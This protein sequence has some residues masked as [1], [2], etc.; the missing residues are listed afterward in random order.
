VRL[1]IERRKLALKDLEPFIGNPAQLQ[2]GRPL[3]Q[4]GGM[5]PREVLANWL[6]C[7]TLNAM[8]GR[9]LAFS[10]GGDGI[11]WDKAAGEIFPTEHTMVSRFNLRA[12]ADLQTLILEAIEKKRTKGFEAYASGMTLVVFLF[13]LDG[14]EWFPNLVA[15]ALP[16]PLHFATVWAVSFS[17][18]TADGR[19]V[20]AVTHL[21]VSKGDAPIF[22]VHI[23]KD[24]D[25]W[26]VD[27]LVRDESGTWMVCRP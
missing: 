1:P 22:R 10:T 9:Q 25:S 18:R 11:I 7:A 12:G 13:D 20:Y 21:D 8:D 19:F 16:N 3:D 5:R 26:E 2:R 24:F 14:Q 17:E 27:G 15:K 6:L 4:F 23:S